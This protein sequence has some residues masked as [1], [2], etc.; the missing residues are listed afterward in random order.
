VAGELSTQDRQVYELIWQRTVASQ[1][2]DATGETVTL[3]LGVT[4]TDERKTVFSTSGTVIKH[5]GFLSVYSESKDEDAEDEDDAKEQMLPPLEEGDAAVLNSV[6][7]AG[8]DT[9]PPSRNNVASLVAKLEELRVGRPS[10]YASI[11]GTIQAREYVWKK[12]TALVPSFKAFAVITLLEEHFPDLV[13]YAFTARMEDDLE[14]IADGIGE[15]IPYLKDFYFG[16]GEA[17][18]LH[19]KVNDRLGDIDA[20]AVNSIPIGADEDG[21]AIVARVGRYG[22]Y[23]E[24]GEDRASIPEDLPPADL[25]IE[26]ALELIL[27]PKDNRVLG[28]HPETG[29]D[30]E[31]KAGRFGPYVQ[32][33]VHDDET[34]EKP[35]TASLFK[36][37]EPSEVTLEQAV[38]LLQ[39]PRLIGAD[40]ADGGE[41]TSELLADRRAKGP[42][43]KKKKAAKKKKATKKKATKKATKKKATKKAAKKATKKAASMKAS[44]ENAVEPKGSVSAA[45]DSVSS[46][47]DDAF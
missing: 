47:D 37:M 32:M 31:V 7:A 45:I 40:P 21:V 14:S 44:P 42:A 2:T 20:R 10:T 24:H 28:Q 3:R 30:V 33:G 19:D 39:L 43:K 27:A 41:I 34:E 22:P 25:T 46:S 15:A 38:M 11:M 18:G 17:P 13:D 16:V 36:S 4:A 26:K 6:E 9:S 35:R 29:I 12:G 1:M 8:H 5:Q 23:L